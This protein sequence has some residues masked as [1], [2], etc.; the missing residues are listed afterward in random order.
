MGTE[1]LFRLSP[2]S[3]CFLFYLSCC[4]RFF[5]DFMTCTLLWI[6]AVHTNT[7][8]SSCTRT[9][10][11]SRTTVRLILTL[12]ACRF[13]IDDGY[14][15]GDRTR[16]EAPPPIKAR[17]DHLRGPIGIDRMKFNCP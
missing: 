10:L 7:N 3:F 12:A 1:R 13:S 5:F 11:H 2:I 17:R 15:S 9:V 8:S 16:S 4:L 14:F 6:P